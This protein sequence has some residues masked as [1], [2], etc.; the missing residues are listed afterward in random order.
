L[1]GYPG[2]VFAEAVPELVVAAGGQWPAGAVAQ[3]LA[4]GSGGTAGGCVVEQVGGQVQ[5][6]GLPAGGFAF[7]AEQDLAVLRVEVAQPEGEGAA[8]AGA[9]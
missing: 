8:A 9:G 1:G 3:Q 4:V 2:Q 5:A 6:D 7:F